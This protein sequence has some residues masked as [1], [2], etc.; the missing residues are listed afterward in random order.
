MPVEERNL[1]IVKDAYAAS[2]RGDLAGFTASFTDGTEIHEARSLPQGGIYK[3]VESLVT[4]MERVSEFY[5]GVN[6][7]KF[8]TIAGGDD[9][10]CWG[11]LDLTGK[12]TGRSVSFPVVEIWTL[13]DGK[14]R[15]LNI[16]YGDTALAREVAGLA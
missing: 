11:E 7:R 13:T 3:G 12:P 4:L 16:I 8:N 1:Q 15:K 14:T 2:A 9:V 5:S 10:V 6:F